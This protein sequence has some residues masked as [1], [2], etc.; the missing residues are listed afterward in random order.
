V[1]A[2]SAVVTEVVMVAVTV[3]VI[4]KSHNRYNI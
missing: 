3:A 1:E 2:A 4:T